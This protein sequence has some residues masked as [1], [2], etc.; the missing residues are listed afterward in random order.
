MSFALV[1]GGRESS[2]DLVPQPQKL[3]KTV[4]KTFDGEFGAFF[5]NLSKKGLYPPQNVGF[6]WVLGL[7][8]TFRG[9]IPR[10]KLGF[11]VRIGLA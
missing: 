11:G 1:R 9:K 2:K 6:W 7:I 5:C 4:G 10:P 3:L 8:P